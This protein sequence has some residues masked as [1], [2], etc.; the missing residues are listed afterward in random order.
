MEFIKFKEDLYTFTNYFHHYNYFL[1]LLA[2]AGIS[3]MGI[4][5]NISLYYPN[6]WSLMGVVIMVVIIHTLLYA[7]KETKLLLK[8]QRDLTQ[9][10]FV[11]F[12][13]ENYRHSW[14]VIYSHWRKVPSSAPGDIV[15]S[16]VEL[17][18]AI[19][20]GTLKFHSQYCNYYAQRENELI[21]YIDIPE[22]SHQLG[23]MLMCLQYLIYG[24]VTYKIISC[25][26]ID[27]TMWLGLTVVINSL[28]FMITVIIYDIR[29]APGITN[30]LRN[31]HKLLV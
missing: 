14:D 7:K 6:N 3:L 26:F 8:A 25:L 28:I 27:K 29:F 5:I 13:L 2:M 9:M 11:G 21:D 10:L 17:A 22:L 18:T 31:L 30:E 24:P 19:E 20:N 1:D 15:L 23:I 4:F 16:N 12:T